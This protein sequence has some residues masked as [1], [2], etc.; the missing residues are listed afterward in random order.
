MFNLQNIGF[1]AKVALLSL[2]PLIGLLGISSVVMVKQVNDMQSAKTIISL[3]QLSVSISDLVHELQKERGLSVGHL[4]S[5]GQKFKQDLDQQRLTT[6]SKLKQLRQVLREFDVAQISA[7]SNALSH[8]NSQ[9]S[10]LEDI[11]TGVSKLE[12]TGEAAISYFSDLNARYLATI[13]LLPQY[14]NQLDIS[15]KLDAYANFLKGKEQ[16]GIERAVLANT[17]AK[18]AFGPGMYERLITLI[19]VQNT[20]LDIFETIAPYEYRQFLKQTLSG[21]F[22]DE[23]AIMR[24]KAL[25]K[26]EKG[27]FGV[28]PTHWFAMQTGKINLLKDIENHI[29]KDAIEASDHIKQH[30]N[31][32]LWLNGGMSGLIAGFSLLLFWILRR[33]IA[34]Q[35][36]G[37]PRLVS[38]LAAKIADGHLNRRRSDAD[39]HS[40]GILAAMLTM[41]KRLADVIGTISQC[42]QQITQAAAEVSSAAQSLSQSSCEQAASIEE[43]SAALEQLTGSVEHNHENAQ[44]TESIAQ[45]AA[46]SAT[47]SREAV[48]ETVSAMEKIAEK[49]ALIEGIAYQTNL[50]SLNASIVAAKA[51]QHGAGFSVVATEVRKLAL[52]SQ[53]TANEINEL[54]NSGVNIAR[55]A[56]DVLNDMLPEIQKTAALVQEIATASDEQAC[57]V[58]QISQAIMQ[59]DTAIQQN[60]AA[61]EQLAATA[62]ELNDQSQALM[63]QVG[64]FKMD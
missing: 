63:A 8:V 32:Q 17:F 3:T 38:A 4:G 55:K 49:I 29:A 52:H 7:L 10:K 35:L 59:L 42:S 44:L 45:R 57:G 47:S 33:D 61:S 62:E 50:L 9:L 19:A 41:Q 24:S 30:A 11:R 48:H 53:D 46:Q 16:A 22:I 36:G 21:K 6:D 14:S 51:G 15:H 20:Y 60:A 34:N 1:N 64:F 40:V 27:G 43:T 31:E 2:V 58:K 39:K 18:D 5:A 12:L 54:A 13:A 25:E 23:T 26:A 28:D 56:D 37:E